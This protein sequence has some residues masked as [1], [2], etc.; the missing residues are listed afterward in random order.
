MANPVQLF[1]VITDS[2]NN[3]IG[4]VLC[5]LTDILFS[6][7]VFPA[8]SVVGCSV[9]NDEINGQNDSAGPGKW[10]GDVKVPDRVA[11]LMLYNSGPVRF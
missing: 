1:H 7:N 3:V 2:P 4:S 5:T 10:F 11:T 9:R 8:K 6:P